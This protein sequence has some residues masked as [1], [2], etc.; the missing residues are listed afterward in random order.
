VDN[1]AGADQALQAIQTLLQ[2]VQDAGNLHNLDLARVM[3]LLG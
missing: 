3:R 2:G 1:A